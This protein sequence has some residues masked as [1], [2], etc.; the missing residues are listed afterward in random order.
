MIARQQIKI[1][2]SVIASGGSAWV[3]IT[4]SPFAR[5]I[6]TQASV[7]RLAASTCPRCGAAMAVVTKSSAL[8]TIFIIVGIFFTV[9][10][11]GIPLIIIGVMMRRKVRVAYQCPR[12][13][14]RV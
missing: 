4:Q 6:V 13:N 3:P 9:A 10:L 14:Y 2:D 11:I 8:A 7:D 1:T 5:F 12:C